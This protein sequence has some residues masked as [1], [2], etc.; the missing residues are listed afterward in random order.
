MITKLKKKLGFTLIEVLIT[1]AIIA[2]GLFGLMV[3]YSNSS[4]TVME[5]D[6]NLM[7]TYLARER[8]EQLVSDKAHFGYDSVVNDTYETT[9]TVSVGDHYFTR[10]F[11]IYE[12]NKDDLLTAEADSGFKRIDMTISWGMAADQLINLSTVITDY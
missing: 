11:S 12:V 6:I 4:Q 5:A 1:C 10:S 7:A 2:G 9:E 3:L 8:L